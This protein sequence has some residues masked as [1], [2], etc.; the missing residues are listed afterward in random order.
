MGI[1]ISVR[2]ETEKCTPPTASSV[3]TGMCTLILINLCENG[4]RNVTR[5]ISSR[6]I[7]G[8]YPLRLSLGRWHPWPSSMSISVSQKKEIKHWEEIKSCTNF[9]LESFVAFSTEVTFRGFFFQ[10]ERIEK[11]AIARTTFVDRASIWRKKV[12]STRID[13]TT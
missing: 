10:S 11:N 9:G 7:E 4:F 13:G 2:A 1:S 5:F 12:C 3:F 6:T 8:Y